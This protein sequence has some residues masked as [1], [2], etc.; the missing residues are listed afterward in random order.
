MQPE[1]AR[2]APREMAILGLVE[3]ALSFMVIYSMVRT[4]GT[5]PGFPDVCGVPAERPHRA[6]RHF[7]ADDR[8]V[9][10]A[11]GLYRPEV[12]LDR[13][14]LMIA[15][16]LSA[17][18]AFAILLLLGGGRGMALLAAHVLTWPGSLGCWLLTICLIRFIFNL[19]L[20]RVSLSRR[21]LLVGHPR[22]IASFSARLQ[23]QRGQRFDP[24]VVPCSGRLLAH[25]LPA[26][27]LGDCRC[28]G[29]RDDRHSTRC[30]IASCAACVS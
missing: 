29:A 15:I 4:A 30:W 14:R 7:D 20:A 24:V 19:A 22:Q 9:A 16:G 13:K 25:A 23:S 18:V 10:L 28:L 2:S 17:A 12:C 27:H 21:V 11:I 8:R 3:F 6:G 5:S 1:M 26:A